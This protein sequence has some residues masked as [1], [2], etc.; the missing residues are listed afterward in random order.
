VA[1]QVTVVAV[2]GHEEL[3]AD[4]VDHHPQLFLR[5]MARDMDEAVGAVIVNNAGVAAL[6]VIDNAVDRLLVAGDDA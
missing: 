5:S 3:R 6:K 1:L 2:N 4:E